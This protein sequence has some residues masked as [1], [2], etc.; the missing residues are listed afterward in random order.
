MELSQVQR[1]WIRL[2]AC[3][4]NGEKPDPEQIKTITPPSLYELADNHSML[5]VTA[6]AL[7]SAGI[8]EHNFN[9]AKT[10]A[11]RKLGLFDIER[12]AIFREL[13]AAGIRHC[14][15]K[16]IILKDYYPEFGMREMTDNDILCDAERMEEIREIMERL[17]YTC[18]SFGEENHDVYSK[19]PCLEFEMHRSLFNKEKTPLY[20]EYYSDVF[21]RLKH[22]GG[23]E[24][25]FSDEDFYIYLI[26][27]EYKH[28]SFN[29][30]G[31]RSL[32]DV[33]VFL[34]ACPQL[35]RGCIDRELEKLNLSEFEESNRTLAFK[36][37]TGEKLS[38]DE[39]EELM[40]YLDSTL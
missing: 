4:V 29:G 9:Q 3:A 30:T 14:P 15:L 6:M 25:R 16:G 33:Y 5:S 27:H 1:V 39:T 32:L 24:Y 26:A 23:C 36:V 13:E 19:P 11:L 38:D 28:F 34:R 17:G 35:D 40:I 22:I 37:F 10:K 8:T 21:S 18:E 12:K 20:Y 31:M 7:E 2:I